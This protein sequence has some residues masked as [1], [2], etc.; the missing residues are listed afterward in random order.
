MFTHTVGAQ[1]WA[2]KRGD[3]EWAMTLHCSDPQVSSPHFEI[4]GT[5]VP[6]PS[7]QCG[8]GLPGGT[9]GSEDLRI[10]ALCSHCRLPVRCWECI[11]EKGV[12]GQRVCRWHHL[13]FTLFLHHAYCRGASSVWG[14]SVWPT[15]CDLPT[16]R[17]VLGPDCWL[18]D[19]PLERLS[20]A[21]MMRLPNWASGR[22]PP[23]RPPSAVL[24]CCH[25]YWQPLSTWSRVPLASHR[26]LLLLPLHVFFPRFAGIQALSPFLKG[27]VH[28]TLEGN[29]VSS[30][31]VSIATDNG[32]TNR[33]R[34]LE[35]GIRWQESRWAFGKKRKGKHHPLHTDVNKEAKRQKKNCFPAASVK[36]RVEISILWAVSVSCRLELWIRTALLGGE[37]PAAWGNSSYKR[38]RNLPGACHQLAL[39]GFSWNSYCSRAGVS[40]LSFAKGQILN[41]WDGGSLFQLF[42]SDFAMQK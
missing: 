37:L 2:V 25:A 18:P 36:L 27:S 4:Q 31:S 1:A 42:R 7:E 30:S 33:G 40:T 3:A 19:L 5:Q 32:V 41:M 22:P 21:R 17:W 8:A 29:R 26:L 20:P 15:H 34:W 13:I 39:R 23:P 38:W 9:P 14:I 35:V 6:P 16:L 28:K 10:S 11:P 24:Q 12:V